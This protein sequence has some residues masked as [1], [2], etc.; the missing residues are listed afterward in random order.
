M[1]MSDYNT[2]FEEQAKNL[3]CQLGSIE[4]PLPILLVIQ[5]S[6]AKTIFNQLYL[7]YPSNSF[8]GK[9]AV[10]IR[11]SV[12]MIFSLL[13]CTTAAKMEGKRLHVLR[14]RDLLD[15]TDADVPSPMK[16]SAFFMVGNI[17]E[18]RGK[19]NWF[20][21]TIN[22]SPLDNYFMEARWS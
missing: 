3:D 15:K 8:P 13:C 22:E 20:Q 7:H 2:F 17:S 16:L 4:V 6:V 18:I 9:Y 1:V 21:P 19:V 12:S 10:T 11:V 5:D 14:R